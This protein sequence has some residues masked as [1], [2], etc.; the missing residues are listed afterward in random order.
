MS[1]KPGSATLGVSLTM[2]RQV[3]PVNSDTLESM[4]VRHVLTACFFGFLFF[5]SE[6]EHT[7][8][9]RQPEERK[10]MLNPASRQLLVSVGFCS[11]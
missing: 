11:H 6:A 10:L 9:E 1:A 3:Y 4:T 2:A 8:R 7:P 5:F